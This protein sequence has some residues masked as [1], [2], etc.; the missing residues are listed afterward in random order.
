MRHVKPF[1]TLAAG[2]NPPKT[3]SIDTTLFSYHTIR[4][5]L[6]I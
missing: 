5:L 1:R 4:D 3:V 6:A 2:Q